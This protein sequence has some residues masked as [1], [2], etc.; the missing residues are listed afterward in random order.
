MF[1]HQICKNF[2][3]K[4]NDEKMHTF[5]VSTKENFVIQCKFLTPLKGR[6]LCSQAKKFTIKLDFA[7]QIKMADCKTSCDQA[8][9]SAIFVWQNVSHDYL[10]LLI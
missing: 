3:K 6:Q 10:Y 4:I 9:K 5:W 8:M 2:A 7:I 1:Q